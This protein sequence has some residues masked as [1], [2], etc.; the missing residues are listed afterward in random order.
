M[1]CTILN[2]SDG[3]VMLVQTLY[4]QRY[5]R[6][7]ELHLTYFFMSCFFILVIMTFPESPKFKYVKKH[8][9][10]VRESLQRI[11]KY[12]MVKNHAD[13]F[14]NTKFETENSRASK[15]QIEEQSILTLPSETGHHDNN[16]N[17]KI[18]TR[19]R[20]SKRTMPDR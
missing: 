18:S 7:L 1:F 4:Y 14:R 3:S 9:D 13:I 6:W 11:A 17:L 8:Y 20:Y 12:N 10:E 15:R 5:H 16:K 2:A 19:P